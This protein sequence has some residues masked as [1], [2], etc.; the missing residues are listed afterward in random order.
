LVEASLDYWI[1]EQVS[2]RHLIVYNHN[3][4]MVA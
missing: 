1:V 3:V 4:G 2:D